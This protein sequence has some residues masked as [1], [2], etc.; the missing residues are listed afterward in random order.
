MISVFMSMLG[1]NLNSIG[2]DATG[3]ASKIK[4]VLIG[5]STINQAFKT[6]ANETRSNESWSALAEIDSW[7]T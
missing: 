2:A 6:S 5:R 7:Y 3:W 1:F 4:V